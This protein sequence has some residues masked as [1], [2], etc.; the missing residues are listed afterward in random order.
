MRASSAAPRAGRGGVGRRALAL[1]LAALAAAAAA[2][3]AEAAA[4]SSAGKTNLTLYHV[5]AFDPDAVCNDGSPGARAR[6]GA[7]EREGRW[8]ANAHACARAAA[9]WVCALRA[10]AARQ[11]G[12]RDARQR[13]CDAARRVGVPRA[14]AARAGARAAAQGSN[15]QRTHA[16]AR[17][18]RMRPL[19]HGN[20]RWRRC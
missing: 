11:P 16:R 20:L 19:S 6:R 9:P 10:R 17:A 2:P 15:M 8:C 7:A 4:R 5:N 1:A 14:R 13:A 18:S 12:A 3:R